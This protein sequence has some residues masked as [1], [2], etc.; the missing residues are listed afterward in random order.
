VITTGDNYVGAAEPRLREKLGDIY[1]NVAGYYGAPSPSQ[2]E[3]IQVL[4]EQ[5]KTQQTAYA[6][7]QSGDLKKVI[8]EWQKKGVQ[9]PKVMSLEE[10]LQV[11]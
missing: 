10:F 1:S 9:L 3:T 7:L 8:A 6:K 2:M 4:H 11:P 5:F